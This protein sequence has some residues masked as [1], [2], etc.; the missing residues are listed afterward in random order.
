MASKIRLGTMVTGIIYRHPSI[1]AKSVQR[2]GSYFYKHG[3]VE[4]MKI[5]QL[6]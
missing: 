5:L 4:Y 1:L 3:P 2:R 6:T